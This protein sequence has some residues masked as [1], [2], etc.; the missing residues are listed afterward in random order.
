MEFAL[1]FHAMSILVFLRKMKFCV[2]LAVL[3]VLVSTAAS[4]KNG[5]A[6]KK[7]GKRP[8]LNLIIIK[9]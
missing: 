8:I 1:A 9:K 4:E 6:K 5:L 3:C 7:K 2:T